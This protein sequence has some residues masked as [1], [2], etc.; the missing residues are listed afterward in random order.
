MQR[1]R[2]EGRSDSL[3]PPS[4]LESLQRSMG[5]NVQLILAQ[6][7]KSEG[8]GQRSVSTSP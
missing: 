4:T 8:K 6:V 2:L 7:G 3:K 1:A 5:S